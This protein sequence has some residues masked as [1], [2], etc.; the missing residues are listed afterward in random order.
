MPTRFQ[1][2]DAFR[3][4]FAIFVIIFH[5]RAIGSIT[6]LA[7]FRQ[8]QIAVEIFFVL[9][10]FVMAHSYGF[11]E[12]LS[13]K[14]AIQSRIAR[15]YPLHFVTLLFMVFLTLL[16]LAGEKLIG[17]SFG[18]P[19][20]TGDSSLSELAANA[21]LIHAWFPFF[22]NMSFNFTSWSISI[23]M[24]LYVFFF[25][26]TLFFSKHKIIAW[27]AIAFLTLLYMLVFIGDRYNYA[28]PFRGLSC[29]FAGTVVY[30]LYRHYKNFNPSYLVAS[31]IEAGLLILIILSMSY[32]FPFRYYTM[33][34]LYMLTIGFFAF[35]KGFFAQLLK[36]KLL[37]WLSQISFSLYMTH[38]PFL[39]V[40]YFVT[41]F[42]QIATGQH[43][44]ESHNGLSFFNLGQTWLNNL[45][46]FLLILPILAISHWSYHRI[47]LPAQKAIKKL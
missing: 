26:S 44:I 28:A 36:C 13:F 37:Q 7:F 12:N 3:G 45:L 22:S 21:L 16:K 34:A 33:I 2:I 25:I 39:I 23:E 18:D 40:V 41:M 4:I 38:I 10:G 24:Y 19:A 46:V 27:S 42:I 20:F 9:S 1:S 6:E 5:I 35:E 14:T 30:T 15:I 29:F 8:T 31:M 32:K 17:F 11:R 43:L 47:E